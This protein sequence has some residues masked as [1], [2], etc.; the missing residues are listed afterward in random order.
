MKTDQQ[1]RDQILR[2]EALQ[3]RRPATKR[4]GQKASHSAFYRMRR[5]QKKNPALF[6]RLATICRD[7]ANERREV[8]RWKVGD[9]V[10]TKLTRMEGGRHGGEMVR[11][12]ITE[13]EN[14][15]HQL[16]VEIIDT[17]SKSSFY[18]HRSSSGVTKANPL[19]GIAATTEG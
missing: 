16:V 19:D 8:I 17:Y 7:I 4:P 2:I 11:G 6:A 18:I 5:I 12:V 13:A 14:D 1:I 15:G 9:F 10:E 3:A